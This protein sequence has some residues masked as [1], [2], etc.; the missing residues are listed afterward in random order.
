MRVAAPPSP[1]TH[2]PHIHIY[3]Q[4]VHGK[5]RSQRPQRR[6]RNQHLRGILQAP[7]ADLHTAQ[8]QEHGQGG[9]GRRIHLPPSAWTAYR[10]MLVCGVRR[11]LA[12]GTPTYVLPLYRLYVQSPEDNPLPAKDKWK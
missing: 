2:H 6:L 7:A 4:H 11:A 12:K 3:L 8:A 1:P 10:G 5:A 9:A